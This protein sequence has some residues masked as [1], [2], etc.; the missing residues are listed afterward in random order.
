MAVS[1]DE[2]EYHSEKQ[3]F[4]AIIERAIRDATG[5]ADVS[6]FD[7]NSARN[8]LM[9]AEKNL[10][11]RDRFW[12]FTFMCEVLGFDVH[13]CRRYIMKQM[14]KQKAKVLPANISLVNKF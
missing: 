9:R 5:E 2:D 14:N 7:R 1:A 13:R 4:A 6:R 12:S 8:W 10:S 11:E 3:L